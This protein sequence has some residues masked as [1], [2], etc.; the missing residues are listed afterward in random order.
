MG[1]N[2]ACLTKESKEGEL[3]TIT[4]GSQMRSF[5]IIKIQ[6]AMRC[7]LAQ[8]RVQQIKNPGQKKSLMAN[9]APPRDTLKVGTL[10]ESNAIEN[11]FPSGLVKVRALTRKARLIRP[12]GDLR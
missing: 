12:L 6:A 3:E 7:Y 2:C 4:D 8:R 5:Y 10:D 1:N 11:M 9:H